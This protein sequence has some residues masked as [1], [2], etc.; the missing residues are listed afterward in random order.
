[1]SSRTVNI[2][3]VKTRLPELLALEGE[4]IIA[5]AN[6]PVVKLVEWNNRKSRR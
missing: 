5:K 3:E 1:M 6:K 4:V 2:Y